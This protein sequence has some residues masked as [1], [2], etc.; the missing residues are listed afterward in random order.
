[1]III[2]MSRTFIIQ[3]RFMS[4]DVTIAEVKEEGRN[5]WQFENLDINQSLLLIHC[6]FCY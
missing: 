2:S 3:C 4:I 5:V 1:M 6:I